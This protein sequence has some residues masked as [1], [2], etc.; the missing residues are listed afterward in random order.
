MAFR[1][2]LVFNMTCSNCSKL[3]FMTANKECKKC[4]LAVHNNISIICDDCSQKQKMCSVCLKK[5]PA[6]S[7][8]EY[9]C[10]ACKK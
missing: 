3:S 7:K 9:G 6:I 4:K 5:I 8:R 1:L 10:G 2:E